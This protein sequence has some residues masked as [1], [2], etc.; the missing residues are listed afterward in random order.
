MNKKIIY[1]LIII[2]NF[3]PFAY[4]NTQKGYLEYNGIQYVFKSEDEKVFLQKADV[5][6]QLWSKSLL[7]DDKT[8]YLNEAMR[9]Y[10]LLSQI[11]K[12]SIEAQIGLGRIYDE[13]KQDKLAKKHFFNANNMDKYN[14]KLNYYLGNFYFKRSDFVTAFHYYTVAYNYGY[15]NNYK[16]NYKLGT[17]YE[18]LADI[19]NAKMH[20]KK[21]YTIDDSHKDLLNKINQ[22]EK[23]N[24]N[25][26]QYY[27]FKS[28]KFAHSSKH[29]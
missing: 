11:N 14:P 25:N 20:Y 6:M 27:I 4:A 16:L 23:L 1:I 9:Y 19:E 28:N 13:K 2:I 12:K 17:T 18:K 26:S 22:L 8:Y 21:A 3:I 24:Y 29:N 5:N 10:Y 15:A 7:P